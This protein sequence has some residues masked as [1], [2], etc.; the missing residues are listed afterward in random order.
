[1]ICVA[2]FNGYFIRL[3]ANW[4]P[5]LGYS[6]EELMSKPFIEFVHPDD[7]DSTIAALREKL[8]RGIAVIDFEN[9]YRCKDGSYKWLHWTSR[10]IAEE[11]ITYAI[12]Y[13]V[14][15]RKQTEEAYQTSEMRFQA[16][17]DHIPAM[18][19]YKHEDGRYLYVNETYEQIYG[20]SETDWRNKTDFDLW[21]ERAE[22][23][24]NN[25]RKIIESEAS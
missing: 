8:E 10:P 23:I 2:E 7:W 6:N 19:F 12:A 18:V 1:M 22:L 11:G 5:I 21:P 25:D 4:E 24:R 17:I 16:F 20:F 15:A 9:R 13:D 3:N 14:S